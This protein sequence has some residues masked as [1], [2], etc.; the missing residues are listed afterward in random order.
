MSRSRRRWL[1]PEVV[2]T[3]AMDCGPAA[4]KGLLEGHGVPVSYGRLR[5]ACQTEVDGTSID[6]LEA[7]AGQLGL[8]A[9]QVMI[10]VDHLLRPEAEALPALLVVRQPDGVTHFVLAWR[11]HGP[12]VQVMDPAVG[13]RWMTEGRLLEDVYAHTL[14]VPAE[15]WREWAA[16]DDF[17]RPLAARL[18]ELG[19]GR[20]ARVLIERATAGSGWRPLATLDA[21][22]RFVAVLVRA[23]G[24]KRGRQAGRLLH[25]LVERDAAPG[26]E[27]I[28][29]DVHWSVRQAPPD[30]D[31]EEQLFFKGAVLVRIRG[32]AATRETATLSPELAA[33]VAEPP[34]RPGRVLLRS[35]R[36]VGGVALLALVA[37]IALA[38]G[39]ELIEAVLLRGVIDLGRDLGLVEQRLTAVGAFLVFAGV[40]LLVERG[41]AGGLAR[42]GRRLEVQLRVAFLEKLPKL[43]DRYF[44]SRPVSDMAERGHALHQ[45]RILP[46]LAGQ[47]L[48]ASAT[49]AA[50]AAAI[51]WADPP[52]AAIAIGAAVVAIGLPIA[53]TPLLSGLDLRVRTHVGAL[54]RFYLDALLGLVAVRAHGAERAVRREHEGLLVE[55]AR[56]SGRLLRWVVI[57]E[58]FQLAIGFGLAGWLLAAHA[59]RA[60]EAGG[61][62]LLAYWVLSLPALGEEVA[63]LARQYPAH[64]S[65]LLRLLEPLGAPEEEAGAGET[66][67]TVP[68]AGD[69]GPMGVAI[70]LE[71]VTVHAGGHT[72]L[73]DVDLRIEPGQHVA[74]VG[75]SGAGKSSLVGLLLG[76][77]RAAAGRVLVDDAPLDA[78]RLE[79]LREETAWVDPAV[80]LWNRSLLDNLLYGTEDSHRPD[81]GEALVDADLYDVLRRLPGGLQTPLGEGGGLL[82]GGQGQRVRLGRALLRPDARLVILDEPFRGLDR[83]KRRELLR[84]ARRRWRGATLLCVT[85]DVG[86][87]RDFGRV[88]VVEAGR[89]AEDGPPEALAADRESR[90]RALLDAEQEVRVG[91]WSDGLWRRL[92]LDEGR[93]IEDRPRGIETNGFADHDPMA[94]LPSR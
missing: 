67:S 15:G 28:I 9:E 92:Q 33:A 89:V 50:T 14:A 36:G 48:R 82:S 18:R 3:S 2:Q 44:H 35:I 80:Q 17:R 91:L 62:L 4:L 73:E 85:H 24:L 64:R 31:G 23:G 56:A 94:S 40:L 47:F 25:S 19:V 49:L 76:W 8:Q 63:R 12:L 10:P 42:L 75:A 46:R 61:A 93:L 30:P 41:V 11:R 57:I 20:A 87:T 60:A 39:G 55:W 81:P 37:G 34:G 83:A 88:L 43:S 78:A 77:H 68:S 51:A 69:A 72:I 5:E 74:I 90:Y 70:T 26:A 32:R 65:V 86:E 45:V 6:V 22:T 38:A 52:G 27:P 1:V 53:F 21:A 71:A 59:G 16:S 79:R 7:V 54:G 66:T 58:G 13:R 29:P 84:R